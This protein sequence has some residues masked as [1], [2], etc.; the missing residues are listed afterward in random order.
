MEWKLYAIV[1]DLKQNPLM[2]KSKYNLTQRKP[3]GHSATPK[4]Q[5]A[6]LLPHNSLLV[7]APPPKIP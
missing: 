4:R 3:H 5:E 2:I 1:N 6:N 7:S